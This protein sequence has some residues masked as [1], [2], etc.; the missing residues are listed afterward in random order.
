M[1][2]R[3]TNTFSSLKPKTWHMSS[4]ILTIQAADTLHI[5]NTRF[6]LLVNILLV[7]CCLP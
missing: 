1:T 3:Q 2:D 4:N 6:F 5:Y 7:P